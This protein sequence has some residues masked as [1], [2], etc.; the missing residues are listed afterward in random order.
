MHGYGVY[1]WEGNRYEG[2]FADGVAQGQ[3]SY[4]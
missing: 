2:D 3:G 1:T 4:T